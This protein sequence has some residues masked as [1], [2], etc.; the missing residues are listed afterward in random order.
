MLRLHN[1]LMKYVCVNRLSISKS[2]PRQVYTQRPEIVCGG[3][4]RFSFSL[5]GTYLVPLRPNW[6][7]AFRLI[8][9]FG[10]VS[11]IR[12]SLAKI[13]TRPVSCRRRLSGSVAVS[14]SGLDQSLGVYRRF[15]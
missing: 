14:G 13:V 11:D 6:M 7:F 9:E 3:M 4:L 8:A 2:R 10:S 12:C 5:P 1:L 15:P